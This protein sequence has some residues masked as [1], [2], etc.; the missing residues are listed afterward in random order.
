VSDR[1]DPAPLPEGRGIPTEDWHQTPLR[2]RL[3]VLTLLQRLDALAARVHPDSSHS[4][5]PPST[6]AP[7]KKRQRRMHAA[8]RRKPGAHP[9][10][11][12]HPQLLLEPTATRSLLPE[13]CAWGHWGSP[14]NMC[15]YL[16]KL[17]SRLSDH[18]YL[19]R[20]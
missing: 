1:R 6:D 14:F 11:P 19:A 20:R 4:S 3:A 17:S 2:V 7:V 5:R 12:G 13:G 8:E 18:P 15:P 16:A 10:H 9:G